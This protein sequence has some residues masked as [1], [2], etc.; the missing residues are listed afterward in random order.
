MIKLRINTLA[1]CAL[2]LCFGLPFSEGVSANCHDQET[3][4]AQATA[5]AHQGIVTP[6]EANHAPLL[7]VYAEP[8]VHKP[9]MHQPESHDCCEGDMSQCSMAQCSGATYASTSASPSNAALRPKTYFR[10]LRAGAPH[11]PSS[12]LFRPPIVS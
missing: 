10:T 5:S 6:I 7:N 8:T 9:H 1:V 2:L 12:T 3:R 4:A 11:H